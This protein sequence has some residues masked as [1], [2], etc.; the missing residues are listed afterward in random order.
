MRP[1]FAQDRLSLTEDGHR[2]IKL[3]KPWPSAGGVTH[4][5]FTPLEFLRPLTALIPPP[6]ANLIRYHGLLGP[7]AKLR[8]LLP[9]APL[10]DPGLR[11]EARIVDSDEPVDT[12]D[13]G[14]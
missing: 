12:G 2:V 14:A 6:F 7:R 1:P 8:D 3:Q 9:A 10:S 5:E 4:L 11:L 13:W